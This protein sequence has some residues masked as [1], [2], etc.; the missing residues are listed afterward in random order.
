MIKDLLDNYLNKRLS[1]REVIILLGTPDSE[2]SNQDTISYITDI[3]YEWLGVDPAK[4]RYLDLAFN[5]NSVLI[6]SQLSEWN[7]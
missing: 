2:N 4:I 7:N 1:Y 5:K 3:E 6:S